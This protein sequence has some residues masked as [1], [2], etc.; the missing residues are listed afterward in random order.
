METTGEIKEITWQKG[1]KI[2]AFD[3]LNLQP[4]AVCK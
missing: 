4:T 3:G 2:E 1:K